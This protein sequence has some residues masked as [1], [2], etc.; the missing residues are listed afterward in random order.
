M[1][2][3]QLLMWSKSFGA[4][5][6]PKEMRLAAR[7]ILDLEDIRGASELVSDEGTQAKQA[8]YEAMQQAQAAQQQAAGGQA[9]AGQEQA[10]AEANAAEQQAMQKGGG[11]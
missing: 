10:P 9:A 11:Q 1:Q 7:L 3:Q 4:V 2:V 8:E 5:L 6:T